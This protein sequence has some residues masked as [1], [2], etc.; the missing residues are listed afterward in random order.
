M[1]FTTSATC[2]HKP[3]WVGHIAVA[4]CADCEQI[5]W[6]SDDGP[7]DPAEAMAA[8]FGTFD[9]LGPLDALG[10]PAPRVLAYAPPTARKRKHLDALP[11]RIWLKAGPHLWVSHDGEVL[12]LATTQRLLFENITKGA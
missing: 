11:R 10:A 2:E 5:D 7:V 4:A 1:D 9:L 6:L 8:V 12:L 3:V